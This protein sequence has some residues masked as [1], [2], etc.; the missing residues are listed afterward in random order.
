M[1]TCRRLMLCVSMGMCFLPL[2][3]LV[4]GYTLLRLVNHEHESFVGPTGPSGPTGPAGNEGI[5]GDSGRDGRD[6]AD[7]SLVDHDHNLPPGL[8]R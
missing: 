6:V 7:G 4:Q 5:D 1:R 2:G 8:V 3:C